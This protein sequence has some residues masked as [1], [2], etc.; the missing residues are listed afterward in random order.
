M[1][2]F[3]CEVRLSDILGLARP[4]P[5][6]LQSVLAQS[7]TTATDVVRSAARAT[8]RIAPSSTGEG[9]GRGRGGGGG[10]L[11]VLVLG[12]GNSSTGYSGGDFVQ[13]DIVPVEKTQRLLGLSS[14][15]R[16]ILNPE[17]ARCQFK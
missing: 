6:K 7:R 16:V 4:S 10:F 17:I 15:L 11:G 3:T 9:G 14:G 1:K 12:K 8:I 2:R 5:A 13:R